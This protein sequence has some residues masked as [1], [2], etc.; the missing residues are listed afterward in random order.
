M[1]MFLQLLSTADNLMVWD[2]WSLAWLF[3]QMGEGKELVEK[4]KSGES[5]KYK[6]KKD[7]SCL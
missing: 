6:Q 1:Q 2:N 3:L 7:V 4:K 5:D